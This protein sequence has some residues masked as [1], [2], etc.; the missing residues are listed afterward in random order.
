MRVLWIGSSGHYVPSHSSQGGYNGGG[1][2]T[3]LQKE[4]M[5]IP[6]II[7]GVSFCKDGEPEKV[8]QN[9]VIYY[10]IPN[11]VKSFKDKIID[12]YH[13]HDV[14]RDEILWPY[15]KDKFR[16]VIDD[17]KPDV[18]HIFGSEKYEG[19]AAFVTGTIP[20]VLH[21]QGLLSLYVNVFLP[22]DFSKW[23]YIMSGNSLAGI[24]HNY[25]YL[26]YWRRSVYREKAVLKAV[27]YLLGRTEWDKQALSILNSKA[28]YY[29]GGELLRDVFYVERDR[30]IPNKLVIVTI[31]SF[32][33]YKG[34]DVILKVANILKNELH[35]DF[36]W[37]VY[38]D[39][40]P[41]FMERHL[42]LHHQNL[43]L[44]LC[45]VASAE[46]IQDSL[47]RC[48][49]YFH[50]SYIE[51]SSN[52]IAEAMLTG[53]PV[54][55]SRVGGNDSLVE[56]GK[57]GFLYPATDPYVAAYYVNQLADN[58]DLNVMF[59][60][61]AQKVA[62]VRHDKNKIVKELLQVYH[63]LSNARWI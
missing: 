32:P 58:K 41:T 42:R 14:K 23:Q 39:V 45:G 1:W 24:F 12:F 8:V 20:T 19:L 35:L 51:N 6:N 57:T 56:H 13:I 28:K 11:H 59:G 44:N 25:Q 38:G 40:E 26:A 46:Q 9:G 60:K 4:M 17:F 34:Y 54:V 30:I 15:Y 43:N 52:A 18:V 16:S 7:L 33:T 37:I 63:M 53:I 31:I 21:V 49:L 27:P 3:S 47:L 10:P 62:K 29:Y 48:T 5:K 36:E 2:I 50:P 22:P 55:A 61:N